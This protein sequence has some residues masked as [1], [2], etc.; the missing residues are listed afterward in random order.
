ML[1]AKKK[2]VKPR[3][4][5]GVRGRSKH[6]SGAEAA[7]VPQCMVSEPS[8]QEEFWGFPTQAAAMEMPSQQ[9]ISYSTHCGAASLFSDEGEG[10]KDGEEFRG[11]TAYEVYEC[12]PYM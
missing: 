9:T 1:E 11:F 3:R 12:R 7:V 6:P 8:D 4:N 5:R 2:G 10:D